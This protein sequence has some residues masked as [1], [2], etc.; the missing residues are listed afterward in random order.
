M[1]RTRTARHATKMKEAKREKGID[2]RKVEEQKARTE[3]CL[4]E[5]TMKMKMMKTKPC[6]K[7]EQKMQSI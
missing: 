1:Q 2:T 6:N 4:N 5:K 3:S 7:R